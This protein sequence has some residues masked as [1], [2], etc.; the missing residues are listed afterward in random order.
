[1]ENEMRYVRTES[2]IYELT[3]HKKIENG[4]LY[5][6]MDGAVT[7]VL[8]KVVSQADD[9]EELCDRT[10]LHGVDIIF[11]SEDHTKYRFEGE[12]DNWY[13]VT[14]VEIRMGVYGG[15][16]TSNGIVYAIKM[17]ERKRFELL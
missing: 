13:D 6:V 5:F 16:W 12:E 11:L 3:D 2:G 1:M 7:D 17:D 8:G 10:L 4:W 9:P 15:I 14:D